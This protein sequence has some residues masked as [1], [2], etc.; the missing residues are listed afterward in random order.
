[1]LILNL[2]THHAD[3]YSL[4]GRE[5]T[6]EKSGDV[7]V[8]DEWLRPNVDSGGEFLSNPPVACD[9]WAYLKRLLVVAGRPI[10][11][12]LASL[13][14]QVRCSNNG[15]KVDL[16]MTVAAMMNRRSFIS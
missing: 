15:T 2:L 5:I 16:D 11:I 3:D 13:L 7:Y 10:A 14:V 1:V 6:V 9:S 4:K 8:I 12:Q